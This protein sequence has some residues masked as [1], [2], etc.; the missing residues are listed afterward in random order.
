MDK[1]RVLVFL[2]V[3][4]SI[5]STVYARP[6][7]PLPG[8]SDKMDTEKIIDDLV[9]LKRIPIEQKENDKKDL[10]LENFILNDFAKYVQELDTRSKTLFGHRS[11]F[12]EMQAHPSDESVFEAI[13]NRNAAKQ[14]YNIEVEKVARPDSFASDSIQRNERLS[15]AFFTINIGGETFH[16]R[17]AGGTI[18]QL[19]T[20]INQQAG[21]K[22]NA[23]VINDTS[24]TAVL[25]VSGKKPGAENKIEFSGETDELFR[26]GLLKQGIERTDD[27]KI[28][29]SDILSMNELQILATP[30][31]VILRS[32]NEGSLDISK[33]N[34]EIYPKTT[35]FFNAEIRILDK[36]APV[37]EAVDN[38]EFP[39]LRI[40]QMEG[41]TL[42]NITVEGGWLIPFYVEETE[43]PAAPQEV[44][45]F[46]GIFTIVFEDNTRRTFEV[47]ESGSFSFPLGSFSEKRASKIIL[48][49]LNTDR[50]VTISDVR[51]VTEIE[52]G[53]IQPKNPIT[54]ASDAVIKVDGVRVVRPD[55]SIDDIIDGV[56]LHLKRES[57]FPLNLNVDYDY[58][59][60]IDSILDW[61]HAYNL[62]MEYL[63]IVT[64]PNLART[65]LHKR[66]DENLRDGV[67]QTDSSFQTLRTRLR[68]VVMNSYP[69]SLGRELAV[70]EQIGIFTKRAGRIDTA[71]DEWEI[72]RMGI[73]D[74]DKDN[75]R[76]SLLTKFRGVEEI[77]ANDT[78]G[79]I[80]RDSGAAV[81]TANVLQLAQ[82]AAGFITRKRQNNEERIKEH[83]R[84]IARMEED[85][86]DY[87]AQ[88]RRRFGRMNQAIIE[89]E[90]RKNWLDNQFKNR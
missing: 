73:L 80:V 44:T 63:V 53:G 70:L 68:N 7:L 67:F 76:E 62:V 22:I 33:H 8:A 86:K 35:L 74:V 39:A 79:D 29:L 57:E 27:I 89:S 83:T 90:S 51:F 42:S 61:V 52:D 48:R 9:M 47:T 69:T 88:E 87:E 30:E 2:F 3:V 84:Q 31:R 45:N 85:I 12:R 78:T 25:Q 15:K 34:I 75:L 60:I 6:R 65:P 38:D 55:N 54:K 50:D 32:Q 40:G 82:G 23:R 71:S 41:I 17:F 81:E 64:R 37:T 46:T 16:I 43:P 20:I 4:F 66:E 14:N 58:D 36:D 1:S 49:N 59:L 11:P 21:E 24:S 18:N 77:F 28:I 10:E 5:F 19:A 56:T 13:A 72:A 26:I